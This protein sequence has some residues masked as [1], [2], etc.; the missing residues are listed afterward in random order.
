MLKMF[1]YSSPPQDGGL[2]SSPASKKEGVEETLTGVFVDCTRCDPAVHHR[3]HPVGG[4][5]LEM[6]CDHGPQI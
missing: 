1:A 4:R 2:A 6:E 3:R 5:N